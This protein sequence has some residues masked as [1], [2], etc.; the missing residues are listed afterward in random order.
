[1]ARKGIGLAARDGEGGKTPALETQRAALPGEVAREGEAVHRAKGEDARARL[2]HVTRT[3][4][5]EGRRHRLRLP[6]HRNGRPGGKRKFRPLHA[7]H[8]SLQLRQVPLREQ[9]AFH[10]G[11]FRFLQPVREDKHF[12]EPVAAL[13]ASQRLEAAAEEV[14]RARQDFHVVAREELPA[15][16]RRR[17]ARINLLAVEEE[18]RAHLRSAHVAAVDEHRLCA[19]RDEGPR[20]RPN[21]VEERSVPTARLPS[22]GMPDAVRD[23]VDDEEVVDV[24]ERRLLAG[25][26]PAH[27]LSARSPA[28]IDARMSVERRLDGVDAVQAGGVGRVPEPL[29]LGVE[30]RRRGAIRLAH[31][32]PARR[33]DRRLLP[34]GGG[35][36]VRRGEARLVHPER[37]LCA[38][39]RRRGEV[40]RRARGNGDGAFKHG[41]TPIR[42][43]HV[44]VRLDGERTRA[45]FVDFR[46]VAGDQVADDDGFACRRVNHRRLGEVWRFARRSHPYR[47]REHEHD[48]SCVCHGDSFLATWLDSYR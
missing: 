33:V 46:A 3:R 18:T 13:R 27:V 11:T 16:P 14:V 23:G 34:F 45:R 41:E 44:A 47:R 21:R 39:G 9:I 29:R 26:L 20:H 15:C 36:A 2:R 40:C 37:G 42:R 38:G 19:V 24:R 7:R 17:R 1:M 31:V 30:P 10:G 8:R 22:D 48:S 5:R 43:P 28:E 6:R 32:A 4:E 25:P 12:A 35:D